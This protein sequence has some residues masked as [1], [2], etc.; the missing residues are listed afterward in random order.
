MTRPTP[1]DEWISLGPAS[2]LLGVD[3][4]TL[5]RWAS[6]GRVEVFS[7]PGGHRRFS[8]A[9]LERLRAERD[10]DSTPVAVSPQRIAAAYRRRFGGSRMPLP[11]P[12]LADL[13]AVDRDGFRARGHR[14]VDVVLDH[15]DAP[16]PETR[17]AAARA[18]ERIGREYGAEAARL[19]LTL[20]D[21][22]AAFLG[23]REPLLSEIAT[24][25]SRRG[26]SVS[27]S[28]RLFTEAALLL[29]RVLLALVEGHG[30]AAESGPPAAAPPAATP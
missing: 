16:D 29:D 17:R 13:D 4:A 5:R 19:D 27:A 21:A 11:R 28:G 8:R 14:L 2:R 15:L 26:L 7:T 12:W 24:D 25:A 22:I 30:G 9:A 3:P 18:A 10:D 1:A 23:S 6:A 20:A